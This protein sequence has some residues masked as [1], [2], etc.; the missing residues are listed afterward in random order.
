MGMSSS[1]A[2]LL[3][4]T[5]RLTD[6]EYHSQ[7]LTN[8][9]MKLSNITDNARVEYNLA[10]DAE[11]LMFTS[12]D[13]FGTSS[14]VQLTPN[15]LYLYQPIKNQYALVNSSGKILVPKADAQNFKNTKTLFEFLKCY[16]DT[17][18][19]QEYTALGENPEYSD[20]LA[21]L[22]IWK[23]LKPNREDYV[24]PGENSELYN[25]FK[26]ASS[27]CFNNAVGGSSGCYL[28]VLAHMLNLTLDNSN[29]LVNYP[30]DYN[31]TIGTTIS[32][33]SYD[34]EGSAIHGAG[35]TPNMVG[36]S[37]AIRDGYDFNGDGTL[38][39]VYAYDRTENGSEGLISTLQNKGFSQDEIDNVIDILGPNRILGNAPSDAE[40]L[41]SSYYLDGSG[42]VKIKTLEQ[43]C[44]D[45]FY[46]IQNDVADYNT[47]LK[48]MI[49]SFQ[50][51][52]VN[53]FN[54]FDEEGYNEAI[55][56]WESQKPPEVFRFIEV[57]KSRII[58]N[59]K[60]KS[61]WYTNLWYRMQGSKEPQVIESRLVEEIYDET[62]LYYTLDDQ[63][64]IYQDDEVARNFYSVLDNKLASSSSWIK[65]VVSQG[66]ATIENVQKNASSEDKK[67]SWNSIIYT[68]AVDISTED[69]SSAIASAEAKYQM[70]LDEVNVKDKR[71]QSMIRKLDT[72]HNALQTEY[73]SVKQAMEKNIDRS[74]K[75]FKG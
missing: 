55:A 27:S 2:R 54:Q 29:N 21:D 20:Y 16:D 56:E 30:K 32:I 60:E 26:T 24:I 46:A 61:Q 3:S 5:A 75:T 45:L 15:L 47:I 9:K 70:V 72:E 69:D 63:T 1:Q 23:E 64:K 50:D 7:R 44:V 73:D 37:D 52:L 8:E 40:K 71:Y 18:T 12:F 31:T 39:S 43:K 62:S 41:L 58:V 4:I 59:D 14:A 49:Y 57:P 68:N 19:S 48:P 17:I 65:D 51:D 66:I 10:L 22:A 53:T 35:Q 33:S 28:H 6:N 67:L 38:D 34:V 42:A 13:S 74:Y 11:K 36:V 25:K